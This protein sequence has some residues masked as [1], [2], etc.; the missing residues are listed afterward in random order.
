M[1]KDNAALCLYLLFVISWLGYGIWASKIQD[2]AIFLLSF[3][4]VFAN[5]LLFYHRS[6]S[7]AFA[8][9]SKM[10]NY[11]Y[12]V[13]LILFLGVI[14]L[15]LI[16][17]DVSQYFN[18]SY[19]VI[20][21][22]ALGIFLVFT[23]KEEEETKESFFKSLSGDHV[24]VAV[25]T[26]AGA[27]VIW[28]KTQDLG[29]I[30]YLIS[31]LGGLL[32]AA[33]SLLLIEEEK[34][35]KSEAAPSKDIK[36]AEAPPSKKMEEQY[37]IK[38]TKEEVASKLWIKFGKSITRFLKKV[39]NASPS[40]YFELHKEYTKMIDIYWKLVYD[41]ADE[42]DRKTKDGIAANISKIYNLLN[43]MYKEL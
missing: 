8:R 43:D 30:S 7:I 12:T 3:V 15:S 17:N 2:N 21:L 34:E 18:L 20:I 39:E 42:A 24:V 27:V 33:L 14:G 11:I 22:V 40:Q 23:N 19:F 25:C 41:F 1:D 16:G 26:I 32:I 4:L 10:L 13:L 37:E 29:K 5:L 31:G 28:Y 6:K 36:E 38:K 35:E 9:L